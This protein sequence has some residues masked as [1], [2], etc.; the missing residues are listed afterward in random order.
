MKVEPLCP[1]NSDRSETR[2]AILGASVRAA[3]VAAWR[4]GMI[5]AAADLFGDRDLQAIARWYR[6]EDYP[7]GFLAVAPRLPKSPWMYTGGLENHPELVERLAAQQP[8]LGNPA[9]VLRTV[10]NPWLVAGCLRRHG[11]PFPEPYLTRPQD[12]PSCR[13]L[14]KPI[15][16]SG[17]SGIQEVVEDQAIPALDR[18][19]FQ[20]F[21][22]G[23]TLSA[24][25]VAAGRC[26]QLWGVT[27]QWTGLA[28]TGARP[29]AYCGSLGPLDLPTPILG[30]FQQI[31]QC[32]AATFDLRGLFGIDTI[33]SGRQV[34]VLEVNPR[35]TSSVEVLEHGLEGSALRAHGEACRDRRL[36]T[37][38][39]RRGS[40][41]YGKAILFAP[42]RVRVPAEFTEFADRL[43]CLECRDTWSPLADL[44]STDAEIGPGRPMVTV[45]ASAESSRRVIERLQQLAT[46]V[47]AVCRLE[48]AAAPPLTPNL[49]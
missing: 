39:R 31:G 40:R 4:I 11:L 33:L 5:P 8:L 45:R 6:V 1:G 48:Q 42:H 13:W 32:L 15:H 46:R 18:H 38:P 20:R 37:M 25:Y 36:P 9:P 44:P 28:W 29:F 17:G 2:L 3:A 16:A 19:Y 41:W 27:R 22:T 43:G 35:Y 7:R 30:K 47:R 34:F 12:R 21:L 26:A 49:H 23:P 10:R 24:V 14:M